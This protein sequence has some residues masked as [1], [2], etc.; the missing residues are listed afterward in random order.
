MEPH[1]P[2]RKPPLRRASLPHAARSFPGPA[3]LVG[4]FPV[5]VTLRLR[6]WTAAFT[7]AVAACGAMPVRGQGEAAPDATGDSLVRTAITQTERLSSLTARLRCEGRLFNL[8]VRADGHY[9]QLNQAGRILVRL[10]LDLKTPPANVQLQQLCDGRF[11]WESR[12]SGSQRRVGRIDLRELQQLAHSDK[13]RAVRL[14]TGGLPGLMQSLADSFRFFSPRLARLDEIEVYELHGRLRR[15]RGVTLGTDLELAEQNLPDSV[16]LLLGKQ[17]LV[18]YRIQFRRGEQALF[19]C[20]LFE[21][22]VGGA[23]DVN[24]FRWEGD[25]RDVEDRTKELLTQVGRKSGR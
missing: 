22:V 15:A 3:G 6:R 24:Q 18:P 4:G 1:A 5:P 13:Q 23:V 8:P 25:D 17:D 19:T 10:E 12:Q 16:I 9:A 21:V 2:G 20:E 14:G 11:L 7:L